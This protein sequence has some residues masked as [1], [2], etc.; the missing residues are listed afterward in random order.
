MTSG[1]VM[2]M[3]P[4]DAREPIDPGTPVP[5]I[6]TPLTIPIQRAFS[7]F[8]AEPPATVSFAYAPAHGLLGAVQAGLTALLEMLKRPVGVGYA[9]IPTATPY[10]LDSL[11]F[12]NRRSL[13]LARSIVMIVP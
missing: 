12:L 11:R 10:V 4:C 7:G 9:G 3:Q 2:R 1:T 5:W 13:K 6:P 8:S